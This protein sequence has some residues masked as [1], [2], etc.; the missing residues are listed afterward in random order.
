[1]ADRYIDARKATVGVR[2]VA[3]RLEA[4][5]QSRKRIQTPKPLG[6]CLHPRTKSMANMG[7]ENASQANALNP[8]THHR[9]N[10]RKSAK[11]GHPLGRSR[12]WV[13]AA[14]R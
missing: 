11:I 6:T 12:G 4:P 14:S 9:G 2:F 3:R 10:P 1:V 13:I 8:S 7:K 5:T